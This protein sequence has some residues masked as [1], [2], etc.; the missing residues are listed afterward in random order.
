MLKVL[1][2]LVAQAVKP[3][4]NIEG[5]KILQGYGQNGGAAGSRSDAVAGAGLADQV[6]QAALGYRANAPLVDAMLR[7]V[8]LVDA[9]NGTLEDLVTGNS[10]L[11]SAV[12]NKVTPKSVNVAEPSTTAK[13]AARDSGAIESSDI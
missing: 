3:I 9:E 10:E 6:T 1:P 13:S 5:I 2:E 7:E 8:G 4:E 12:P 11:L